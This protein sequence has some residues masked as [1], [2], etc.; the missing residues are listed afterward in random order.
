MANTEFIGVSNHPTLPN[1]LTLRCRP[2]IAKV[3][4]KTKKKSIG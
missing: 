4:I 3:L 1:M 2:F